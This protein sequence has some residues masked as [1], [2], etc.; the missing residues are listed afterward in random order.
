MASEQTRNHVQRPLVVLGS[1]ILVIAALYWA[2]VILIPIALALLLTFI[3]SPMVAA[4]HR[5]GLGRTPSVILVVA[6]VFCI[7]GGIGWIVMS[8]VASLAGELPTYEKN[9]EGKIVGLREA[10][11]GSFLEKVQSTFRRVS[12]ELEREAQK[13]EREAAAAQPGATDEP[14]KVVVQDRG[15]PPL[16]QLW[17]WAGP[18]LE[19]L[20]SAGLVIILVIFMLMRREDLRNR[21]ISLVGR[22]RL[23]VTTKALDDAGH[24]ISRYLLAQ[25]IIN[26]SFGLAVA[27]G[28]LLIGVPHAILWG[29]LAA[30]LRYIPY[31]GPWL[32]AV[33]PVTLSLVAFEGWTQPV[34]VVALFVVLELL[35]NNIMEPLLYGHSIGV[36]EVA[37]LIAVAFWT[38][39]WGAIG[40]VL[41]APLTV[42]L[43][44]LAKYVPHLEFIT[45]LMGDQ[46]VLDADVAY[47]QR[48]L[49]RD[50]DEA[51]ELVDDHLKT[52]SAEQVL[53][54]LDDL[55]IPTLT[56]ARRDREHDLVTEEDQQ[57]ILRAMREQV[58][59]LDTRDG[60]H[61][62]DENS[63][64]STEDHGAATGP[65]VRIV[66]FPAQEGADE[67]ALRMFEQIV[68]GGKC[69]AEIA[70]A[71]ML[72]SEI[73][74]LVEKRKPA[75]V[76]IS[77]LPP[78]GL[79]HARYLCKRLR[80]RFPKLKIMV[81]RWG[82][83]GNLE[84]NRELLL[85]AGADHVSTTLQDAR[86]QLARWIPLDSP[87]V[88]AAQA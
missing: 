63:E 83:T 42:C 77:A 11:K 61:L 19:P 50:Q 81:G 32:A 13:T 59:E 6:L 80:G 57:F 17:F 5:A 47:Y 75:V 26:G 4:L 55:L 38:W 86:T 60:A 12:R 3:L 18:V 30:A 48:L 53:D 71:D 56:Y 21:L 54:V 44:V 28:L 33:L 1:L 79:S 7:L 37:L 31:L 39:L 45:T 82:L 49:A 2:Q 70:S 52:H 76:C 74:L 41:A 35:S 68:A 34:L 62:A 27:L 22:G 67:L 15:R 66:A 20:A 46:E 14:V 72:S 25:F 40:L 43:V 78:G 24:R 9:I 51:A 87:A 69:Q 23:T 73:V 58:E 65:K 84:K 16:E 88:L 85:A 64:N 36:S 10:A 8:Q 29:F